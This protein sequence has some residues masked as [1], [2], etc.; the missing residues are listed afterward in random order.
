MLLIEPK[1]TKALLKRAKARI[2]V[3]GVSEID[4]KLAEKDLQQAQQFDNHD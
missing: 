1:S 3:D 4:Y 2:F